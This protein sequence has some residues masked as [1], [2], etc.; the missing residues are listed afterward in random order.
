MV[1]DRAN[2]AIDMATTSKS[3]RE[4]L[5]IPLELDPGAGNQSLQVNRA[6]RNAILDGRLAPGL[7][8]P[9]SRALARQLGLRRNAIIAAYEHLSSDGFV[10]TRTG[11]GT[12][13]AATLPR[14]PPAPG[15]HLPDQ[16]QMQERRPFALG[17]T[18]ADRTLLRK[19]G[20][21]L[22]RRTV[23]ADQAS[24]GYGDP[25]G[26]RF[27]RDQIADHLAANRGLRC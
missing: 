12:Y 7:R 24:L 20:A 10:E 6:L 17:D 14:R 27:L 2:S 18:H 9:S 15:S 21:A 3:R 22:R 1:A 19:L 11:A 4:L 13:V 23:H 26:S 16:L 8:L 5:D 25:R